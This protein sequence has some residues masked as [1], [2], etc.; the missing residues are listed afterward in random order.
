MCVINDGNA[1]S[2]YY[3]AQVRTI[4]TACQYHFDRRR[5]FNNALA[6]RSMYHTSCKMSFYFFCG[7]NDVFNLFMSNWFTYDR[8]GVWGFGQS[9]TNV[10]SCFGNIACLL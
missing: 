2:L 10:V 8:V 9:I 3:F 7:D 5:T 1:G 6:D 4:L